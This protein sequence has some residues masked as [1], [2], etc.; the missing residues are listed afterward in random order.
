MPSL[1]SAGLLLQYTL[2]SNANDVSSSPPPH[3]RVHQAHQVG[4]HDIMVGKRWAVVATP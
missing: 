3:N 2:V 1:A 4:R